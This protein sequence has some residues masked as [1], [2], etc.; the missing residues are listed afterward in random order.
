MRDAFRLQSYIYACQGARARKLSDGRTGRSACPGTAARMCVCARAALEEERH[1]GGR[2]RRAA[3]QRRAAAARSRGQGKKAGVFLRLSVCPR[4]LLVDRLHVG[5][6]REQPPRRRCVAALRHRQQLPARLPAPP[7][8]AQ[9]R[10]LKALGMRSDGLRIR[11][12]YIYIYIY[13]P[14][15]LYIIMQRHYAKAFSA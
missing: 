6:R 13:N 10:D 11:N 4:H 5:A 14:K 12:V 2:V 7:P 3:P 8:C 15:A 1:G 9:R